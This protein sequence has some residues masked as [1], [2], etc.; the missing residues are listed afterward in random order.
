MSDI[1]D[2]RMDEGSRFA[3]ANSIQKYVVLSR[4]EQ[5]GGSGEKDNGTTEK[6]D[7]P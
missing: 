1:L 3:A 2:Y 5:A 6:G 4:A 7:P